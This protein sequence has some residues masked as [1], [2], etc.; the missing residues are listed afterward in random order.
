MEA[1]ALL[2]RKSFL[3]I[4]IVNGSV[5]MRGRRQGNLDRQDDVCPHYFDQLE[6]VR[7]WIELRMSDIASTWEERWSWLG[8]QG[9][10]YNDAIPYEDDL[11]YREEWEL[12]KARVLDR[13]RQD[14]RKVCSILLERQIKL[15][16]LTV[17]VDDENPQCLVDKRILLNPLSML[18]NIPGVNIY[19]RGE[20]FSYL[21][22]VVRG[23]VPGLLRL[24]PQIRRRI[25]KLLLSDS[26]RERELQQI[27]RFRTKQPERHSLLRVNRKIYEEAKALLYEETLFGF[28]IARCS[29]QCSFS[30]QILRLGDL[31]YL[32]ADR[33][34]MMTKVWVKIYLRRDN[35]N[36]FVLNT[37]IDRFLHQSRS[38]VN[39]ALTDA[40]DL[41]KSLTK[42]SPLK[43]LQVYVVDILLFRGPRRP[44]FDVLEPFLSLHGIQ[45]ARIEGDVDRKTALEMVRLM[46]GHPSE[47]RLYCG[48]EDLIERRDMLYAKWEKWLRTHNVGWQSSSDGRRN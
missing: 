29:L 18:N 39:V 27:P 28:I 9:D 4:R 24:P 3:D 8:Y 38:E 47:F 12:S 14:L 22:K 26:D 15:Q 6:C 25:F 7:I 11:S 43:L 40:E 36:L 2:Y 37:D 42:R 1:N 13:S 33:F 23:P 41:C 17:I 10:P 45:I 5:G 16:L 31:E 46:E 19:V 35:T 32:H 30:K 34:R 20:D 48:R 21:E 44:N